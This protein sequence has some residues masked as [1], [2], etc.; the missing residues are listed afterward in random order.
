MR[1]DEGG[2]IGRTYTGF[3]AALAFDHHPTGTRWPGI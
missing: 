3:A 1:Q 2:E